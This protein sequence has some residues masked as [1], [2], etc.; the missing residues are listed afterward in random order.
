MNLYVDID[1][2][3]CDTPD[4]PGNRYEHAIPLKERIEHLNSLYDQGYHIT[5]WTARGAASKINY[6]DLTRRQLEEWGCK[7]H[8]LKCDKPSYDLYIDDKC[9]HATDYWK[10]NTIPQKKQKKQRVQRV[11]KGWGHEL[12]FVNND[13]YCGK[14]LHFKKDAKFSMHYH[15]L[16]KETWYV[17]SGSFL[18][19]YIDTK[20]ADLLEEHLAPGD[21]ITN[22]IGE[23]HQLLCLEEGDIM[24]VSTTHHDSDSYRVMKGD[25]Q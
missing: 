8:E 4:I 5:Y 12:I 2:T 13:Q 24:E 1:N 14:I 3:I 16:K 15:L 17:F 21:I 25:S 6:E 20:T 9:C 22:E 7:Y 18:F 19:R 11:E 10:D 23:P